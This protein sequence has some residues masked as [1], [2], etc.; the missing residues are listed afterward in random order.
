M[1]DSCEYFAKLKF[2]A[3]A[4]DIDE[5]ADAF[6]RAVIEFCC[7]K[8]GDPARSILELVKLCEYDHE[9]A[10]SAYDARRKKGNKDNKYKLVF[11]G[12]DGN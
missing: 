2:G 7:F 3:D 10:I 8:E 1:T 6:S 9:R 4:M 5:Y 11:E 12:D